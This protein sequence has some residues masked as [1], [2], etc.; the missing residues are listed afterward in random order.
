[1]ST[2]QMFSMRQMSYTPALALKGQVFLLLL[3]FR[4][5]SFCFVFKVTLAF[6]P[7]NYSKHKHQIGLVIGWQLPPQLASRG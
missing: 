7:L 5:V 6:D 2:R 3:L 1:M 4:F